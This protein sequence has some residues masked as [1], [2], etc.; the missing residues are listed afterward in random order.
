M[1]FVGRSIPFPFWGPRSVFWGERIFEIWPNLQISPTKIFLKPKIASFFGVPR[2]V[3]EVAIQFPGTFEDCHP[4]PP[5]E[6][7]GKKNHQKPGRRFLP[8]RPL[9]SEAKNFTMPKVIIKVEYAY[10]HKYGHK[11]IQNIQL[12]E[13]T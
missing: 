11:K 2:W 10:N 9:V 5:A 3:R 12:M 4:S 6:F 13:Y 1:G 8:P 7:D